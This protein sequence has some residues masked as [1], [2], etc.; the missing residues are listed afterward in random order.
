LGE[1][2][3]K[4][5]TVGQAKASHPG[6]ARLL[7]P[8]NDETPLT[9]ALLAERVAPGRPVDRLGAMTIIVNYLRREET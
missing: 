8:L 4:P 1:T 6:L 2:L 3:E 9:L 7:E 5:L